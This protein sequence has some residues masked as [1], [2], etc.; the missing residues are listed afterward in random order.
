MSK[1]LLLFSA[2]L[3]LFAGVKGQS[4]KSEVGR[5][6]VPCSNVP[7]TQG[8]LY[9]NG[10]LHCCLFSSEKPTRKGLLAVPC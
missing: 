8:S 5:G 6:T 4:A 7:V 9:E 3:V 2:A 1:K 10:F